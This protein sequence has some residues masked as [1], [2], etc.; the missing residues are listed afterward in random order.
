MRNDGPILECDFFGRHVPHHTLQGVSSGGIQWSHAQTDKFLL[1]GCFN[2]CNK[3]WPPASSQLREVQSPFTPGSNPDLWDMQCDTKSLTAC[4]SR[5]EQP[6]VSELTA[7]RN[8]GK[9]S[10][11]ADL[12]AP[13][14]SGGDCR[15]GNCTQY[16]RVSATNCR[17]CSNHQQATDPP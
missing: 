11:K 4:I 13:P 15:L 6:S 17:V 8:A 2:S 7:C 1:A 12:T 9:R 5:D 10:T 3:V 14:I 16:N